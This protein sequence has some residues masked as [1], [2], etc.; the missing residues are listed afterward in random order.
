MCRTYS[1]WAVH[2]SRR[3][4]P[5]PW[6]P[7]MKEDNPTEQ[8]KTYWLETGETLNFFYYLQQRARLRGNNSP[9]GIV[10]RTSRSRWTHKG[11]LYLEQK[12]EGFRE[13]M[14]QAA[15]GIVYAPQEILITS[16]APARRLSLSM[17]GPTTLVP[18]VPAIKQQTNKP[19]RV[20]GRDLS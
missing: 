8:R 16:E 6:P 1:Y 7:G 14:S 19:E 17:R 4:E 9:Y 20:M 5:K 10:L 13:Q 3:P 15:A 11:N 12:K 18:Y 2:P